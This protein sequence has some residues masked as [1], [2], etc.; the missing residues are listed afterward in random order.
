AALHA[1]RYVDSWRVYVRQPVLLPCV[2]LALLYMT[3]LSLGFLMTSYLKWSGMSEAEVSGYRGV[4]ALTGLAA[5]AIF[6][7]LSKRAGLAFCAVAGVTYQLA[8]LAAGVLP[9]VVA[10]AAAAAAAGNR[11]G[12]EQGNKP[13]VGQ[14]RVLVA[15]LV[16]SRTGLWL[17]DLAVTQLIQE[18][19]RQDLL[20]NVYG[21]QSS[22]QATFEML[23]FVAGLAVSNPAAFHWLMLGSLGSVAVAAG[24][25]WS[26]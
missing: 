1:A 11:G 23:S 16:T 10:A 22:L 12:G 25:V 19:V 18:D 15:G 20:G 9:T 13:A 6:P 4:G 3:V 17:Y 5:T 26:Y 8:C 21:V 14:V 2:A 24:L 7:P